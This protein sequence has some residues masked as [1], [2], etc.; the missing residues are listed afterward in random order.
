[1]LTRR[2]F[3][4]LVFGAG[5]CAAT[6]FGCRRPGRDAPAAVATS[7][8]RYW[9]QILLS[10]GHDTLYTTDPKLARDVDSI[11]TLPTANEIATTG[12]LRFGA[13]FAPLARWA[14]E[15]AVVNG[16]QVRTV[17]HDTGQKQFF[18]LKTNIADMMPTALDVIA[19]HRAAEQPL[20]VAYLNMSSRIMHSPAYFGTADEFYFGK[21][22]VFEQVERAT[23]EELGQLASALRRQA[24][25]L[26]SR[27]A[28]WR[29]A[30]QTQVYLREVADFFERAATVPPLVTTQRS[31]DYVAQSMVDALER[32]LWLLE[33][34]LCCGVVLDLGVLGWDTHVQNEM[35]QAEMN[36]Y[37][38][39]FFD[40]Y[41]SDL[42][43]R[44]NRHGLLADNTV[45]VVGSELGRFPRQNE[46]LGKDHLPQTSFLIT[47]PGIRKG[48]SFGATGRRMEGLEVSYLD[49]K[50]ASAGRVPVLDDI[51]TT[52]LRHAGLEPD[53]YGYSGQVCEFLLDKT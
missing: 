49:G 1:M 4:K 5:A 48:A 15:L 14:G 6:A 42:R 26:G 30:E 38:V 53:R 17:N 35:K 13:H 27:A 43:A 39:K 52:L 19:S 22:N 31:D 21:G 12:D 28:G 18:H 11:V 45:T 51:G 40:D 47:G 50:V 3:A 23:P 29:E 37:F 8:P 44:K 25:D 33:N 2:D 10:G 46:M 20:G 7:R 34:D 41:L 16:I 36:G 32:T 24:G 9:V